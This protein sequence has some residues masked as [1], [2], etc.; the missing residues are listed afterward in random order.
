MALQWSAIIITSKTRIT[1]KFE[2][3]INTTESLLAIA[4]LHWIH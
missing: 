1:T 2:I 3:R 4:E